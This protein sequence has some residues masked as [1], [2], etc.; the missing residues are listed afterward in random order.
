MAAIKI[1]SFS[2]IS[3]KLDNRFLPEG[4][5]QIADNCRIISGGL[6]SFSDKLSLSTNLLKTGGEILSV[7]RMTNGV[8]DYWLSWLT[9]VDCVRSQI[10]GDILQRIYWTG[11]NE[12]RMSDYINATANGGSGVMPAASF[13]LGVPAP[14][15][16]PVVTPSGGSGAALT[17]AYVE[18]FVTPWGE[19]SAPSPVTLVTGLIDTVTW[20]LTSLNAA[21]IN[22]ANITGI[23]VA[24]G[25]ATATVSSSAYL[26]IGEEVIIAD[27][28]GMTDANGSQVITEIPDSTHI[29]FALTTAQTYTSGGT[30]TRAAPH[31]TTGMTRRIYRTLNGTYYFVAE[32]AVGTTSYNDTLAD[33]A[34][35][36]EIPSVGWSMPPTNLKGLTALPNGFNV[37]F[38]GNEIIFSEPWHPH[39][40]PSKYKLACNFEVVS[41][42]AFGTS[43]VVGT[44]GYPYLINGVHPS[45]MSME[46]TEVIEPCTSKRSM[47]D[48]GSGV[49]YSS[50]NGMV[51]IGMG[52]VNVATG[53]MFSRDEW[54]LLNPSS[55]RCNFHNGMVFGWHDVNTEQHTGFTYKMQSSDFASTSIPITAS[56]VDPETNTMYIVKDGAIYEWDAHPFNDLT[57]DWKS[58]AYYQNKPVN[59]GYAKVD[60]NFEGVADINAAIAANT[61][62]NEAALASGLTYGEFDNNMLDEYMLDGSV[63]TGGSIAEY[64][65]LSLRL[66]VY[67]DGVTKYSENVI[68]NRSFSLPSGFKASR[69]EFRLSG[70]IPAYSLAV[71]ETATELRTV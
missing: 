10:A 30:W 28:V 47:V 62:F 38:A 60:A 33:T 37:G 22:S 42:G 2:G 68:S 51:F 21:P 48:I 14:L 64:A 66:T 55:L 9:D 49:L 34:L 61:A 17:R 58:R 20:A 18:T 31:N 19:E 39:A 36:E 35:G 26:R 50:P 43:I 3:P 6:R 5:A 24:S 1:N 71:A 8:Y 44:K 16:A 29:K 57:F 54:A 63:L 4:F 56:Y 23:T 12:P 7:F 67:A 32:I 41:L 27:V 59:F 11:E 53:A 65:S 70:N 46:K 45:S 40:F 52:G 15:V 25:S 13:V 69:W